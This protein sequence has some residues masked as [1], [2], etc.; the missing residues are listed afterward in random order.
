MEQIPKQEGGENKIEK[1]TVLDLLRAKGFE[2][3]EAKEAVMRWTEQR[4][5]EVNAINTSRAAIEFNIERAELYIAVGD[6]E[7]ALDCLHDARMQAHQENEGALYADILEKM[8]EI[9]GKA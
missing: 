2:D 7:G 4:E 8:D 5:A 9:E 3:G 1:A 6:K